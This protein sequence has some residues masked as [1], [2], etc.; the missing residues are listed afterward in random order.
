[1]TGEYGTD[2]AL[3]DRSTPELLRRLSEQTATLV[4]QELELAK[5]EVSEKGRRAGIGAGLF[6]GAGVA[7]LLALGSL[8]AALI[9]ALDLALAGWLAALI[10]TALWGA[11]AAVLGLRGRER[12]GEATPPLPE[13][14]VD[15]LKED[16]EWV[17]TQRQS[18]GR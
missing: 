9:L 1:M 16:V 13:Q 14:T 5:A 7:G 8:S 3:R 11:L 10:V 2:P 15:T 17:K 4:R 18:A 6:G 12:V